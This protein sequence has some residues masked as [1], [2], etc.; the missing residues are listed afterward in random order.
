M[1]KETHEE[2]EKR[3]EKGYLCDVRRKKGE[4]EGERWRGQRRG[5]DI[6][7]Q[8]FMDVYIYMKRQHLHMDLPTTL[9]TSYV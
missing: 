6:Y 9:T 4:R 8:Q 2:A 7:N 5:F 3:P 1:D